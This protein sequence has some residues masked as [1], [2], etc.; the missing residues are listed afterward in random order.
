M[1][2]SS[3]GRFFWHGGSNPFRRCIW[4][5]GNGN[6]ELWEVDDGGVHIMLS[7]DRHC[8]ADWPLLCEDGRVLY[9]R[10]E[11]FPAYVKRA[12]RRV[13]AERAAA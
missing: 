3:D 9:D 6:Y 7:D 8:W 4:R 1:G 5:A 13:L 10:P 2:I 11:I 12:V